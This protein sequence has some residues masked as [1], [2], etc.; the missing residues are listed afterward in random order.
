MVSQHLKTYLR[1]KIGYP[2]CFVNNYGYLDRA[3]MASNERRKG[4]NVNLV[5][6]VRNWRLSFVTVPTNNFELQIWTIFSKNNY[7]VAFLYEN[8]LAEESRQLYWFLSRLFR[9]KCNI[10]AAVV[11]HEKSKITISGKEIEFHHKY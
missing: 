3:A 7:C 11:C 6:A 5:L 1:C 4:L 2:F 9:V 8:A 10:I